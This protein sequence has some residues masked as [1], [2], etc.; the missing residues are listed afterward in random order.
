MAWQL[1]GTVVPPIDIPWLSEDPTSGSVPAGECQVVDVTFDS[2]G[3]APGD[4]F[5]G[6]FIESNDPD[7]PEVTIP[8]QLTVLEPAAIAGVTYTVD[9]LQVTFDATATG[10]ALTFAWDFGDGSTSDLEDPVHTYAAGGCYTVTLVVSNECGDATWTEQI[11]LCEEATG[12]D[13]T[14]TPTTP[15]VGQMVDFS[16]SIAAGTP[17]FTWSWDFGDGGTA[18]GQNVSHTYVETGCYTATLTVANTCGEATW[19]EE[20]CVTSPYYYYYLPIILRA[21]PVP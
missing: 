19:S 18:T 17:P 3:L 11:C 12:A 1:I 2:T 5:A 16:G 9:G 8:V 14:W 4:Y 10:P 20:I 21:Y 7:A 13:F 6:L 15:L